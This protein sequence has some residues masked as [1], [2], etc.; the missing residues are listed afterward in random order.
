M[1]IKQFMQTEISKAPVK[2]YSKRSTLWNHQSLELKQL[3]QQTTGPESNSIT[4]QSYDNLANLKG[5][6]AAKTFHTNSHAVLF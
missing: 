5:K 4:P 3:Q 6:M 2:S 1:D